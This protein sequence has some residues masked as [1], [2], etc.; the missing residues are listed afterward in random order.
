MESAVVRRVLA[1]R[2]FAFLRDTILGD[3]LR[4]LRHYALIFLVIPLGIFDGPPIAQITPS[5]ELAALVVEAMD[6]FMADHHADRAEVRSVVLAAAKER[7]LQD[8]G[9]EV[10]GVHLAIF[11]CVRSE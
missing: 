4:I 1:G 8:A 7:K 9:R 2:Q 10:D 11:V 3:R 5:I 6:R